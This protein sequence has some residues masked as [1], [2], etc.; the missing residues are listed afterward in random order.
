MFGSQFL[1]SALFLRQG[2][3]LLLLLLLLQASWLRNFPAVF[4][5]G[6]HL[7]IGVLGLQIY[8]ATSIFF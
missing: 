8:V 4:L 3:S 1:P 5:S 2:L 7:I 6:S